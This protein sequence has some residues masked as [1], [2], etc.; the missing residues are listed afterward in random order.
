MKLGTVLPCGNGT[1][2]VLACGDIASPLNQL[3]L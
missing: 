3:R 2:I 1:M